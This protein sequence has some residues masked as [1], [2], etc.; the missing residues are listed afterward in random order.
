MGSTT[1]LRLAR[2]CW[3]G[4]EHLEIWPHRRNLS[5]SSTCFEGCVLLPYIHISGEC[6][7]HHINCK[8]TF[9]WIHIT[10]SFCHAACFKVVLHTDSRRSLRS[11]WSRHC[12]I[13]HL[14]NVCVPCGFY[15]TD[16]Q[17]LLDST[18]GTNDFGCSRLHT[19]D[20]TLCQWAAKKSWWFLYFYGL[21]EI[22]VRL[23]IN[24]ILISFILQLTIMFLSH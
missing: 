20:D 1:L 15:P 6:G 12:W 3:R 11:S 24:S 23:T 10:V 14:A 8:S 9:Y 19:V 18:N 13:Q 7:Y 22:N 16:S 17:G 4:L 5:S 21:T 2:P